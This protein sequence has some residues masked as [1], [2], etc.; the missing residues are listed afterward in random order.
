MHF[1]I[2]KAI[3]EKPTANITLNGEKLKN[4]SSK[5][6]IKTRIPT[7]TTFIQHSIRSL[8]QR[9]EARKRKDIKSERKK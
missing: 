6:R 7:L 3:Y 4:F 5:F 2:T 8:R 1:N 9:N